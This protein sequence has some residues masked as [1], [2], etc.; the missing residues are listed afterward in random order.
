MSAAS[1]SPR[2]IERKFFVKWLPPEVAG[3]EPVRVC[4]GYVAREGGRHVRVRQAGEK[5]FLTVKDGEGLDRGEVEI[6]LTREQFEALWPLT[7]GRRVEKTRAVLPH[8]ALRVEI[9][10][11]EGALAPLC[12][13]EVEFASVAASEAFLPPDFF[14][15]EITN[16]PGYRNA[17]LA[18][19]GLPADFP[20]K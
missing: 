3:V 12:V 19:H 8:G 9:D 5:F 15:E 17:A 4:Q 7:E 6:L 13:A 11:F 18:E 1:A 2:E 16:R 10:R 14:G 20:R